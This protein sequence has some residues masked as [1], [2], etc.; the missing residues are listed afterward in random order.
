MGKGSA[1]PS[2]AGSLK[3]SNVRGGASTTHRGGEDFISDGISAI[4]G[5]KGRQERRGDTYLNTEEFNDSVDA[6]LRRMDDDSDS[7]EGEAEDE[8]DEEQ[9]EEEEET[10]LTKG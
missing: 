8:D 9:M 10:R 7:E 4:V 1:T 5:L 2:M 6:T 3:L